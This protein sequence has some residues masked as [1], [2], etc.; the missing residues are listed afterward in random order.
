MMQNKDTQ[1]ESIDHSAGWLLMCERAPSPRTVRWT[2]RRKS[3]IVDAIE[4]GLLTIEEA[5]A[6]YLLSTE[7]LEGWQN[8]LRRSGIRALRITHLQSY[9]NF[10]R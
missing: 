8:S 3:E 5:C 9:R 7:E 2:A 6:R 1:S 4:A 10:D